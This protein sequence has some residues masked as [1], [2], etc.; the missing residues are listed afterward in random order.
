MLEDGVTSASGT[1]HDQDSN[2]IVKAIAQSGYGFAGWSGDATGAANPIQ[3]VMT[4]NKNITANFAIDTRTI[5]ASA[6]SNGSINPS[7]AVSVNYGASQTFTITPNTGYHVADVLVYV[8]SV[9]AETSYT[10]NNVIVAHTISASFVAKSYTITATAVTA[11]GGAG[12]A[13]PA[14]VVGGARHRHGERR[15][16]LAVRRVTHLGI[17]AEVPDDLNLVKASHDFL[18]TTATCQ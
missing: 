11:G 7:G 1:W 12:G 9:S 15:H 3:I 14:P 6:G 18:R 4:G 13:A 16:R 5:T 10:F 17:A 2:V 8:S